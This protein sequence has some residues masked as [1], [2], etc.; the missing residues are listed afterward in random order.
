[1][2]NINLA[3]IDYEELFEAFASI[4]NWND[5]YPSR[6]YQ[7]RRMLKGKITR[8]QAN[9]IIDIWEELGLMK[10]KLGPPKYGYKQYRYV[11]L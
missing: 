8:Q 9:E 7:V 3:T 11:K 5:I 6:D 4:V 1:M 10:V 2:T